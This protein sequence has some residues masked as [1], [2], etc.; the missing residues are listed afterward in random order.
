MTHQLHLPPKEHVIQVT[1]EQAIKFVSSPTNS[2]TDTPRSSRYYDIDSTTFNKFVN[3]TQ[4]DIPPRGDVMI[5]NNK[6]IRKHSRNASSTSSANDFS[7]T[8][9]IIL[10]LIPIP[11]PILVHQHQREVQFRRL[12]HQRILN[13]H[14]LHRQLRNHQV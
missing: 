12:S 14:H 5:V 1:D 4:P 8:Q 3:D 13:L 9:L 11:L 2:K 6:K 7:S 10:K